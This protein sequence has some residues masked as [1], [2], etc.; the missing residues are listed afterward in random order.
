[1][2]S[3]FFLYTL[4]YGIAY[5]QAWLGRTQSAAV[6]GILL[7]NGNPLPRTLVKLYD[8]DRGIDS[9]DLLAEG[10]SDQEGRF[11]LSGHTDETTPIDPKLNIYHDC[12]DGAKPC[13]REIS[14]MIPDRYITVGKFARKIYDA[15]IIELAAIMVP[16]F[17]LLL[18]VLPFVN[19]SSALIGRTQ[20]A[21]VRGQ[22]LCHGKP[23]SG[24]LVK[25]YDDDR[26][27]DL[28]DLMDEGRS[29]A[30]GKF[31]LSGHVD[32]FTTIDPKLN[33]YHDC[34]DG[35]MPCQRRITIMIPDSYVSA[36]TAVQR[37]YEAGKLELSGTWKGETRDCI[38]R[39]A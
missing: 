23:M 2:K 27:I 34:D 5:V 1:M 16:G 9:D 25:L 7:C 26:G 38:H 17:I 21:G 31:Q 20:S 10:H 33:I 13:Q 39:R 22:L 35:L 19:L 15:G 14:I 29:D 12:N 32:E 18:V 11:E 3:L 24:V 4:L 6:K 37:Y 36:G 8:D 28:D 30:D